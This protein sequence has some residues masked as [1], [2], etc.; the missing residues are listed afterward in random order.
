MPLASHTGSLNLVTGSRIYIFNSRSPGDAIVDAQQIIFCETSLS[1]RMG[2][3]N[4]KARY[5]S[6]LLEN[7]ISTAS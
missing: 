5:N 6:V 4:R 7:N 1:N 2:D 3:F